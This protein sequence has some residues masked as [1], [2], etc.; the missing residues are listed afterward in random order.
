MASRLRRFL[1]C[2]QHHQGK[3]RLNII[4]IDVKKLRTDR[5]LTQMQMAILIGISVPTIQRWEAGRSKLSNLK[6]TGIIHKLSIYDKDRK[7]K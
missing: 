6:L 7:N 3:T 5:G 1:R 4:D 2:F